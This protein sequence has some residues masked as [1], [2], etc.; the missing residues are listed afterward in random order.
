M[1]DKYPLIPSHLVKALEDKTIP[2]IDIMHGH[3]KTEMLDC[4][5]AM[6][7]N[8]NL[9]FDDTNNR[10]GIATA[11]P[12]TALDVFGSGII[13]RIN[14]TSTNNAYLGFSSNGTNKWSAG[15]V[16]SDHRFRIFSE[17]NS[18]ELITILQTGEFGIGIANPTTKLHIDGGASALIANLDANVS[19]AKRTLIRCFEKSSSII[20]LKTGIRPE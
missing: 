17:A 5:E 12:T 19:V 18:A 8:S 14:G 9:F 7:D 11:S 3:L 1:T 15:N 13:G 6:K 10:L 16:Q 4:E 2:L 20:S